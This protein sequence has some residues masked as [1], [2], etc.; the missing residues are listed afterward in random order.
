MAMRVHFERAGGFAAPAMRQRWTVDLD[1]LPTEQAEQ[2]RALVS[3]ADVP[4]LAARPVDSMPRA[5]PDAFHYRLTID[6]GTR[7]DTVVASDADMPGALWPLV[8]WLSEHP[9]KGDNPV[10]RPKSD[11]DTRGG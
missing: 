1:A 3:A 8:R 6:D 9:P 4:G 7:E 2:L 11:R 10:Q 5:S